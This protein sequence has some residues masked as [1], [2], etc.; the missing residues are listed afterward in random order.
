MAKRIDGAMDLAG[1]DA[2]AVADA[3]DNAAEATGWFAGEIAF[4]LMCRYIK[5]GQDVLDFG[6]GTGLSSEL[7]RSA[8]LN[9]HGLDVDPVMLSVCR[10]KGFDSLSQHDLM[11]PPYPYEAG[12]MD[13]A[14]C[15]GVML[16]LPELAPL[17]TE[18]ARIVRSTGMFAFMTVHRADEEAGE[19]AVPGHKPSGEITKL[20][21]HC[22]SEIGELCANAGFEIVRSLLF[23]AYADE[24]HQVP[25]PAMVYIAKRV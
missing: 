23:T 9:V 13:H 2:Q 24:A 15:L 16:F 25:M 18:A 12:S 10:Y 21:C 6:I 3:Y 11:Q 1:M 22:T 19:M 4:G 7:F 5:P 14:V 8:G 20:Y 17:F